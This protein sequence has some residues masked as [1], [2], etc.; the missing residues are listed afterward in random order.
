LIKGGSTYTRFL[1]VGLIG[2]GATVLEY[3]EGC[4]KDMSILGLDAGGLL[5]LGFA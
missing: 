3:A 2:L 1:W 4:N 5:A